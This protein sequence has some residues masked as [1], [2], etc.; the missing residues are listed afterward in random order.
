MMMMMMM[1]TTTTTATMMMMM[2]MMMTMMTIMNPLHIT[3]MQCT[4]IGRNSHCD[5]GAFNNISSIFTSL[6]SESSWRSLGAAHPWPVDLG[7]G[8]SWRPSIINK[9]P[10][11]QICHTI[12]WQSIAI[13][14]VDKR[15]LWKC[16]LYQASL[17]PQQDRPQCFCTIPG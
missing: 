1:M 11:N 14:M 6:A 3:T 7:W 8:L 13:C 16:Y 9:S 15:L 17:P 4:L 12:L 5:R 10:N 2:M